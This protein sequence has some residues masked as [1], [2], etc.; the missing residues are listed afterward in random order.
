MIAFRGGGSANAINTASVP[1]CQKAQFTP[2]VIVQNT[3]DV[4]LKVVVPNIISQQQFVNCS[5]PANVRGFCI[6][7]FETALSILIPNSLSNISISY[8]CVNFSTT[9]NGTGPTYD[10]MVEAVSNGT[11]GAVVGDVTIGAHRLSKVDFAQPY[12][13]SGVV[14]LTKVT[15]QQQ[16]Y[17]SW[18]MFGSPFTA[19]MW[20]TIFGAFA[21]TGFLLCLLEHNFHSE[22]KHGPLTR[23][24]DK[25]FWFVI[26]ALILLQRESLKS[27]I[28]RLVMVAWVFFVVIL[29]SSYTAG[30][31]SFLTA[32]NLSPTT[33]DI[34]SLKKSGE[35]I[36]YRKGSI[37]L[38][39]LTTRV[40]IPKEQLTPIRNDSDFIN[41][42]KRGPSSGG[43]IAIVDELPY[44]N[45]L[46]LKLPC[47]YGISGPKLTSEGFGFGFNKGL[48]NLSAPF[49]IA[50]LNLTESGCLQYLE[51]KANLGASSKCTFTKSQST[52]VS[53]R[54]SLL[55]F[56]PLMTTSIICI[57]I[58][59]IKT[60]C[61]RQWIPKVI[62]SQP[63]CFAIPGQEMELER[64]R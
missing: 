62:R 12:M 30:L 23:R 14:I 7:V 36:G 32:T 41:Y 52:Q 26:E 21:F 5:D 13:E 63:I 53:L 44:A 39:Y 40:H 33:Q 59:W 22:F 4:D 64:Y 35:K 46:L 27:T 3:E 2:K 38:D 58:N 1:H 47:D 9:V 16:F 24:I 57:I 15:Q 28:A 34:N 55:L 37:V 20:C 48:K 45:L 43:V 56:I 51:E 6:D 61:K 10:D 18:M 50:I 11:Y 25:I 29:S 60:C 42:I 49:S 17:S 19:R 8:T 54:S 31:S